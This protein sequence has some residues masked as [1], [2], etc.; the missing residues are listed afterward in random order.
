MAC[1]IGLPVLTFRESGVEP[2]GILE[3]GVVGTYGPEVDLDAD[4]DPY[5]RGVAWRT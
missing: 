4:L 5:F 2:D 3:P 1:Q